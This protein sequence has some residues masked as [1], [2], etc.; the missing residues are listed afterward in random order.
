MAEDLFYK[1]L[2]EKTDIPLHPAWSGWLWRT[3]SKKGWS[4]PL[5]CPVG[6]YEGYLVEI[7]EEELR[8]T[9][10]MAIAHKDA[11]VM[12]CFEKGGEYGRDKQS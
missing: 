8:D 10:T 2:D 3:F 9:I 5:E 4:T 7:N 12:V 6:N 1:Q 11:E